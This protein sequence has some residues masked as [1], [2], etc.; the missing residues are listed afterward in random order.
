MDTIKNEKLGVK[1]IIAREVIHL[2]YDYTDGEPT[3]W[4]FI[5]GIGDKELEEL[6]YFYALQKY[7]GITLKEINLTGNELCQLVMNELKYRGIVL[8]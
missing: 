5:S 8:D 4:D 2:G 1:W 7:T 6:Y 3:Q